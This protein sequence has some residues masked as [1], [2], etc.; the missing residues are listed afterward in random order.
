MIMR[1]LFGA[2]AG[3]LA[4][5]AMLVS[6]NLGERHAVNQGMAPVTQMVVGPDGVARPYLV[7]AGQS[8]YGQTPFAGQPGVLSPYAAA[9]TPGAVAPMAAYNAYGAQPQYVNERVAY[10]Q[11]AVRRVTSQR[12]YATER[13]VT[14]QRSWQKSAM[15]IGGSAASGAGVGA[16]VGGKKGAGIGALIGGG[17]AT[18]FDQIKRR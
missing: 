2:I 7:Q 18:L 17:A 13:A 16:I 10:T 11:P 6:Y 9:M 14:P 12:S 4:I 5:V 1:T 3:A 8:V 15:L